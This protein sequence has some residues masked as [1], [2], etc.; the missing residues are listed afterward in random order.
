MYGDDII[1]GKCYEVVTGYQVGEDEPVLLELI[2]G[3]RYEIHY[4]IHQGI[5]IYE[6]VVVDNET[7]RKNHPHSIGSHMFR[8]EKTGEL[9]FG[10]YGHTSPSEFTRIVRHINKQ[11]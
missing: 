10:Y 6:G 4:G 8:N 7:N 9:S 3:H 5:Y 2:P 11:Q 1:F